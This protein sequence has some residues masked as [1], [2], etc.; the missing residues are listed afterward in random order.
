MYR[1]NGPKSIPKRVGSKHDAT[2]SNHDATMQAKQKKEENLL[3]RCS[4]S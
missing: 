4:N 2:M 1:L 3:L